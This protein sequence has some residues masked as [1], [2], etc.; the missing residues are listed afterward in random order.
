MTLNEI[1]SEFTPGS[2]GFARA[3]ET[4]CAGFD[5]SREEIERIAGKAKTAEEFQNVW[6]NKDWWTDANN[7]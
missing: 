1:Y 5:L 6:E 7:Q 4:R 3:V 2:K